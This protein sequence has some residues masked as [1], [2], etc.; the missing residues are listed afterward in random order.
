M[1]GRQAHR[2]R[3][4]DL[5]D[6][7]GTNDLEHLTMVVG[8]I[9]CEVSWVWFKSDHFLR[10]HIIFS[11]TSL[12]VVP[13]FSKDYGCMYANSRF[14]INLCAVACD[15]A[16]RILH[17]LLNLSILFHIR[18]QLQIV[19]SFWLHRLGHPTEREVVMM[20]VLWWCW[21]WENAKIRQKAEKMLSQW[22]CERARL[23]P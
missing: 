12:E 19:V 14:H 6:M 17:V 1:S 11:F 7:P 9:M 3:H 23:E 15:Y 4:C 21:W 18:V 16:C 5:V 8:M 13:F 20:V 10:E 2:F 22:V